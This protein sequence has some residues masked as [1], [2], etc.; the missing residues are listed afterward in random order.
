[1]DD[2]D[3]GGFEAAEN[4][5]DGNG[6]PPVT[7]PAIP[8][9]AFPTAPDIHV[10]QALSTEAFQ[11]QSATSACIVSS[12]PFISS[13]DDIVIEGQP[14]S[15]TLNLADFKEQAPLSVDPSLQVPVSSLSLSEDVEK[16]TENDEELGLNESN[17]YLQQTLSGLEAKLNAADEEKCRIKKELEDLLEK[18]RILET[19]FL[20]HK[21]DKLI[22]NQDR[23]NKLQEK[24]KLELEDL[25]R[26]GHEALVIIVEEFKAL[27]HS[28]VQQH[29]E[30]IEKRYSSVVEKQAHKCEELLIAQHQRLLDILDKEHTVL[31]EK[32]EESLLQQSQEYKKMLEKCMENERASNKE[33][34]AAAAKIEKEDIEAA[35]LTAVKAERENMGKLHAAEKELWQAERNKNHEM[36]AQAIEDTIQEQRQSSQVLLEGGSSTSSLASCRTF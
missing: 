23:Y 8:W 16:V 36:I 9:A 27:L 1:M 29:E 12:D 18:Y 14:S 21:E 4:Y 10:P 34:L 19:D 30:A 28:T 24:H 22:S 2:D 26:A 31:E 7:S 13:D 20:K 6:E 15:S 3:F 33:A 5:K 35:I 32:I 17:K 25:R 11:E